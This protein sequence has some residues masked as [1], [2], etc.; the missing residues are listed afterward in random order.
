MNFDE[1]YKD[2]KINGKLKEALFHALAAKYGVEGIDAAGRDSWEKEWNSVLKDAITSA[3][4]SDA[5][6][7]YRDGTLGGNP[8]AVKSSR[9]PKR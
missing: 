9:I 7:A 6:F 8:C 2:L 3:V 4:Q 1:F 5:K